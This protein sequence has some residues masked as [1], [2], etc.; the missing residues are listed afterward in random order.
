MHRPPAH[1]L[2]RALPL[3][4]LAVAAAVP[5]GCGSAATADPDAEVTAVATTTH[6]A[7]LVRNV[8]GDRVDV[9]QFLTPGTDPHEYEPRPSDAQAV[10]DAAVVFESGGDLDEWLGGVIENAGGDARVVT[11]ADAVETIEAEPHGH[12]GGNEGSAEESVLDDPHWW[13]DPRNAAAA[14]DVIAGA[15]ADADPEGA[16]VYRENAGRYK[17]RLRRLDAQIMRCMQQIPQS[18]RKLVTTHDAYGHFAERY[19][20]EVIGALIP[21]RSTQAQPSAGETAALVEQIEEQGVGAVFPESA[22]N[23]ELEE[24]VADET[25]ATVGDALWGDSL[26]P[27]GSDGETYV[28]ALASDAEAM[29]NGFTGR[30]GACRIEA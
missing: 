26:G 29:A 10:A 21:S 14:V 25:G 8:G 3:A 16:A 27:E 28:D 9:R 11:L 30:D 24:A 2:R 22:L 15:L 7:D 1:R 12:D 20:V 17:R 5:A 19:G 18:R 13:Q 6:V 23:P 4:A